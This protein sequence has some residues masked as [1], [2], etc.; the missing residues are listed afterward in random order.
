M[1]TRCLR[2]NH[3]QEA[4]GLGLL[5][6]LAARLGHYH[7]VAAGG[8]QVVKAGGDH[9]MPEAYPAVGHDRRQ[10]LWKSIVAP[11]GGPGLPA[12]VAQREHGPWRL[13]VSTL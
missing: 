7:A 1:L 13:E 12:L 4:V 6:V 2:R 5:E 9:G 3:Q 11:L 8:H 10:H